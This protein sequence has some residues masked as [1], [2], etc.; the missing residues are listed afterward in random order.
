MAVLFLHKDKDTSEYYS[1]PES[2]TIA[3]GEVDFIR[4]PEAI[5]EK[6]KAIKLHQYLAPE[7]TKLDSGLSSSANGL[8]KIFLILQQTSGVNFTN[9][10]RTTVMRRIMTH[11]CIKLLNTMNTLNC[12]KK[13]LLKQ[14]FYIKIF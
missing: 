14:R 9:Y 3:T 4:S 11:G 2:G 13:I 12:L 1:M 7:K 8:D 6:L 5:A 10:K